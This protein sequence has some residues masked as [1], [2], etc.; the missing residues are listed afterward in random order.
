M[1]RY[2]D[3][4]QVRRG[5]V[6]GPGAQGHEGP[7]QFLWRGHLW[8]VRAVVAQWAETGPW[9]LGAE[10]RAVQGELVGIDA[11]GSA[12]PPVQGSVGDLL[13]ERELWRVEAGRGSARSGVFDLAFSWTDGSWRLIGCVD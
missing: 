11:G 12:G 4:V 9:W 1:R 2:D 6:G 5:W 13:D 8:K 3:S 7:E 10:A